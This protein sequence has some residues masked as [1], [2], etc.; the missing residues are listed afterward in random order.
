[1][2]VGTASCFWALTGVDMIACAVEESHSPQRHIPLATLLTLLIVTALYVGTAAGMTLLIPYQLLD[3]GAPLPSAFAYAGLSRAKYIVAL[4]PLCGFTTAVISSVFS[5]VRFSLA[6][7]EDGLL[8]RWFADVNVY[9]QVPIY[10]VIL[11]GLLQS[12]IACFC[13]IRDLISFSVS[14]VLLSYSF[15]C[16]AVIVLRY[17]DI[18]SQAPAVDE[19]E[20]DDVKLPQSM[21]QN[22]EDASEDLSLSCTASE[23]SMDAIESTENKGSTLSSN[24]NCTKGTVFTANISECG[25]VSASGSLLPNDMDSSA[26]GSLLPRCECLESYMICRSD[27]CIKVSLVLMLMSMLG[28]AFTLVYGIVPLESG[29]WWSIVLVASASCGVAL[30]MCIIC[31][32]RQT[33]QKAVLMV[34]IHQPNCCM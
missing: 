25:P 1:V 26:A 4:G 33:L 8:W 17:S 31:I 28:L 21:L 15:T 32:H 22:G 27:I 7:A 23:N 2:L 3:I 6:M 20:A 11:C 30:F 13:D 9:T 14:I 5:F 18:A 29:Q 19:S 12:L 16:V 10:P 34:S 24:D